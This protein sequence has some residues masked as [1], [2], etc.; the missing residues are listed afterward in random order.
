[1]HFNKKMKVQKIETEKETVT[2]RSFISGMPPLLIG[3]ALAAPAILSANAA[4]ASS[5]TDYMH[6]NIMES[7]GSSLEYPPTPRWTGVHITK[8]QRKIPGIGESHTIFAHYR[9]SHRTSIL[10][11]FELD[12]SRRLTFSR[13]Q[14]LPSSVTSMSSLP[15]EWET[16][17]PRRLGTVTI[18]DYHRRLRG[19]ANI[20]DGMKNATRVRNVAN[21]NDSQTWIKQFKHTTTNQTFYMASDHYTAGGQTEWRYVLCKDLSAATAT[22]FYAM[23]D[24]ERALRTADFEI[25]GAIFAGTLATTAAVVA[26]VGTVGAS[27]A[28]STALIVAT[29]GSVTAAGLN[30]ESAVQSLME[31]H[32]RYESMFER[33]RSGVNDSGYLTANSS[34]ED[35]EN[36]YKALGVI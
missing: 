21:T 4:F 11:N 36:S 9:G 3:G 5:P 19:R 1:M 18:T 15:N 16:Q 27:T 6:I 20:P 35:F 28:P 14:V 33:P 26:E 12:T 10:V 31:T 13:C 23:K 32:D 34:V 25:M 29:Y 30:R 8:F 17:H 22:R 2:R 7:H 24:A